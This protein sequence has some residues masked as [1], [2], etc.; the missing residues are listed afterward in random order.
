VPKRSSGSGLLRPEDDTI[1]KYIIV[2]LR[3]LRYEGLEEDDAVEWVEEKLQTL[4]YTDFSD[5]LTDNPAEL[6]RNVAGAAKAVWSGNGY[7]KDPGT[8]ETKL[9]ASVLTWAKRGFF[10]SYPATWH[11]APVKKVPESRLVW[12]VALLGLIPEVAEVAHCSHDK[13]KTF[14][15]LILAFVQENNELSE[16]M[17]SRLLQTCGIKG[18]DRGKQYDVRKLLK[19]R[20][21]LIKVKNYYIDQATGYRHG[22]FHICGAEVRFEEDSSDTPTTVSIYLSLNTLNDTEHDRVEAEVIIQQ[23]LLA[24][25]M[26]Y[27]KRIRRLL[28]DIRQ[29]A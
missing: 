14:I 12:T 16:S 4:T 22:D 13:A 24:C 17:V 18:K 26:R 9:K 6:M 15:E 29:A 3:V 25:E 11:R 23:R 7:Q 1:G 10:L 2:S 28:R 8:S 27:E 19:D 20:R 5:R 21:A